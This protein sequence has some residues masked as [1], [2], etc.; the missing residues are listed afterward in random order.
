MVVLAPVLL[1]HC[2]LYSNEW[3]TSPR[4]SK[5]SL[6]FLTCSH[7]PLPPVA[8]AAGHGGSAGPPS[9]PADVHLRWGSGRDQGGPDRGPGTNRSPVAG[10][11]AWSSRGG[12]EDRDE[13]DGD[14]DDPSANQDPR[15]D[16][17]GE[18]RPI[19]GRE[20][21]GGGGGGGSCGEGF[22]LPVR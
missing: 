17:T 6:I 20:A 4:R 8:G 13:E 1:T 3:M 5:E 12:T 19:R 7:G 22:W 9:S 11:I 18:Q 14:K 16:F 10:G 21:G 15:L 2:S